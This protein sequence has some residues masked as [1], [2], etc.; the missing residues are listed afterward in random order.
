MKPNEY[1]SKALAKVRT[2]YDIV[3]VTKY[4]KRA[5]E[6]I[7]E[8]AIDSIRDTEDDAAFSPK[9]R[10]KIEIS[11]EESVRHYSNFIH[12]HSVIC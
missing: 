7:E 6:G 5:L 11:S 10:S 1:K 2:R 4:R 9:Q 3:L 12:V 8:D